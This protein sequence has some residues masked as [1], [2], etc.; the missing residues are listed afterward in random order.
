MRFSVELLAEKPLFIR[1]ES[2]IKTALYSDDSV[3][4]ESQGKDYYKNGFMALSN[5]RIA[6]IGR[7][8]SYSLSSRPLGL[9]PF[10][11]KP[12][13]YIKLK[14]EQLKNIHII[15]E[16]NFILDPGILKSTLGINLVSERGKTYDIPLARPDIK[17]FWP[18][19]GKFEIDITDFI[20]NKIIVEV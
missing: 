6:G 9:G 4:P 19:R 8:F 17:I 7:T 15:I 3:I 5:T 20:N 1:D 2:F 10:E 14:E 18:E 13:K 11:A 12:G 16:T